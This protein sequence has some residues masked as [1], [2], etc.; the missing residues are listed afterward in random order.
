[1]VLVR[2]QPLPLRHTDRFSR[3]F[4]NSKY[5]PHPGT[6]NGGI[7]QQCLNASRR[8]LYLILLGGITVFAFHW[9]SRDSASAHVS[10]EKSRKEQGN[11]IDND[12]SSAS[13]L[14]ELSSAITTSEVKGEGRIMTQ[15]DQ[16]K[17]EE[18]AVNEQTTEVDEN[19]N[20]IIASGGQVG[21]DT[22]EGSTQ[23]TSPE[24]N[25]AD[26]TKDV[27]Y[28]HENAEEEADAAA[29]ASNK[30]AIEGWPEECAVYLAPS[31]IPNSGYG[32]FTAIDLP[33]GTQVGA[34]DITVPFVDIDWH[35][36][37][38]Y[39]D[40][41]YHFLYRNYIWSGKSMRMRDVGENIAVMSHGAGAL[42]NSHQGLLNLREGLPRYDAAGLHRSRDVGAGAFSPYYDRRANA[43][44]FVPAGAEL[45][46]DYGTNYFISRTTSWG[47]IPLAEDYQRANLF[48]K[49]F[50]QLYKDR[51]ANASSVTITNA[52]KEEFWNL[53]RHQF[54]HSNNIRVFNALPETFADAKLAIEKGGIKHVI[55][56]T[57][58]AEWFKKNGKCIDS[59]R[60]QPSTIKQAGRG[61]FATRF[62][63]EGEVVISAPL[64]HSP[65]GRDVFKMYAQNKT[66]DRGNYVRGD[67][68]SAIHVGYQLMLNYA[69]GHPKSSMLMSP[70]GPGASFI[71]HNATN[72]NV[73]LHWADTNHDWFN[74]SIEWLEKDDLAGAQL[75]LDFVATKDIL[76]GDEV[77][78]DYGKPWQT[79]WE[80]YVESWS[81]PANSEDWVSADDM[82][83]IAD[84]KYQVLRT[85]EEQQNDP[86]PSNIETWCYYSLPPL[87]RGLPITKKWNG[88]ADFRRSQPCEIISKDGSGQSTLYS[89]KFLEQK[90]LL[91][92]YGS[93]DKLPGIP[94][95][96]SLTVSDMPR[97]AIKFVDRRYSGDM[98]LPGA[99]RHEIEVPDDI[100]PEAWKNL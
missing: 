59:I 66:N 67:S 96:C 9:H 16:N 46:V 21:D 32:M 70:Y 82:N 33:E 25:N 28:S 71:N 22:D 45:F 73:R 60:P 30:K 19:S 88:L 89:V 38:H 3:G 62:I 23:G 99:F 58:S 10:A 1:M 78:L 44:D 54:F 41:D 34:A 13:T 37:G 43:F 65:R 20:N 79:A 85:M 26:G 75:L 49:T 31:T 76:P 53:T 29:T 74:K 51:L 94:K 55:Q 27:K 57:K 90:S 91:G 4:G 39:K 100:W 64:I 2:R 52:T 72:A 56:E 11:A 50:D 47:Y 35:N 83:K 80:N 40:K 36:K 87:R 81:P 15:L 92:R 12:A 61:A 68:E 6:H 7:A 86:Y 24:H 48:L 69:F 18:S 97:E 14:P 5:E 63:P 42:V 93:K 95:G 8:I 77:F 17:V 84:E 98:F